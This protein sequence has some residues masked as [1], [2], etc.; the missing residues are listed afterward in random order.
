MNGDSVKV[1]DGSKIRAVAVKIGV[2]TLD[3]AQVLGG[4]DERSEVVTASSDK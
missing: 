4:L 2:R 3:E 1:K